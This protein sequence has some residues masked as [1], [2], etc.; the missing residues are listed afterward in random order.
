MSDSDETEAAVDKEWN[1]ETGSVALPPLCCVILLGIYF[2][3]VE[4]CES[5]CHVI[6]V[7]NHSYRAEADQSQI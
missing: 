2:S 3:F 4:D 6:Q 7:R 1:H 5:R